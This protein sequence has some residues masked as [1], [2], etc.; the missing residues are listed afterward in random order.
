MKLT[1]LLFI[2]ALLAGSLGSALAQQNYAGGSTVGPIVPNA[3]YIPFIGANDFFQDIVNGFPQAQS[4][5]V[6]SGQL[7]NY[8]GTLQGNNFDNSLVGGDFGTNIWPRGATSGSVTTSLTYWPAN[9][10]G[11]GGTSTTL[12]MSQQTGATDIFPGTIATFRVNKNAGAGVVQTCVGQEVES[13]KAVRFQGQT[14]EFSFT[15][16]AGPTFSAAN[17]NLQVSI[18]WG[19]GTDEGTSK[20][21]FAFNG[22]GGGSSTWAG[23]TNAASN[24]L[25]PINTTFNRY[26][27][28]AAIPVT[29]TEIAVLVC[30]TPVG[31]GTSTDWFEFGNAQLTVNSALTTLA[32][33]SG[34]V[35][36]QNDPRI[37]AYAKRPT[38]FEVALQQRYVYSVLEPAVNAPTGIQGQS[39]TTTTCS[40]QVNF[41]VTMRGVPAFAVAGTALSATTFKLNQAAVNAALATTFLVQL[42]TN[43]P[44]ASFLTGTTGAVQTA[45]WGCQLVGGGTTQTTYLTWTAE[46]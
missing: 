42:A 37:K 3:P 24:L 13:S 34:V 18:V 30:Y 35:L 27:V 11:S 9:W 12:V 23:Q 31:T 10:F 39:A 4:Q 25:V 29:A 46:L 28:A 1:R 43:T 5:Y 2:A 32:G 44:Y 14:A 19:T 8:G 41:P 45:G 26:A 20:M 33:T 16:K 17:S 6:T 7:G 38:E 15:A 36:G 22:Q 40:L 21:L